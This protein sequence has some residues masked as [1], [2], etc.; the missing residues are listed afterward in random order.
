MGACAL[1]AADPENTGQYQEGG[2]FRAG[3]SGNPKG[4]PR[5]SRNRATLAAEALLDG[6]AEAL[7]RTAIDL[8]LGGDVTALRLCLERLIPPRRERTLAFGLPEISSMA[9]APRALAA[10]AQAVAKGELDLS[11]AAEI[12]ALIQSYVRVV[13]VSTFE[14]RVRALEERQAS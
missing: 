12:G 2:R 5:G 3:R 6:E 7:T 10:I 11:E 4:R 14:A 8:A 9:D 1:S 13:E